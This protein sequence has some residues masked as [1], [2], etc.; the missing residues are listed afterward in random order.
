M[1]Y[2]I[3]TSSRTLRQW[4][5][6]RTDPPYTFPPHNQIQIKLLGKGVQASTTQGRTRTQPSRGGGLENAMTHFSHVCDGGKPKSTRPGQ[7]GPIRYPR[8][9]IFIAASQGPEVI[10]VIWSSRLLAHCGRRRRLARFRWW[11]GWVF[12][13][14]ECGF[15]NVANSWEKVL[16]VFFFV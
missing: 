4:G 14:V 8:G 1:E 11:F 15:I 2:P 3:E 7:K 5:V 13:F 12:L 10:R 9:D 6:A 16:L